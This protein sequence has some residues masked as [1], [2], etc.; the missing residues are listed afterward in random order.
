MPAAVAQQQM[1]IGRY[2][3]KS[4]LKRTLRIGIAVPA[5]PAIKAAQ[6]FVCQFVA[7]SAFQPIDITDGQCLQ[8]KSQQLSAT[9]L[10]SG[11]LAE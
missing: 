11:K 4:G 1:S 2:S 6:V 8:K 7:V 9:V 10:K 5:V 3:F